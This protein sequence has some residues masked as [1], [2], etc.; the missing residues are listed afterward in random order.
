MNAHFHYMESRAGELSSG[1]GVKSPKAWRQ[2]SSVS[3]Q[4]DAL[5]GYTE[6]NTGLSGEV[7]L[8]TCSRKSAP[9]VNLYF[10]I[11]P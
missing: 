3:S 7:I 8:S 11:I 9:G 2:Q 10:K 5:T 1:W 4:E 6:G